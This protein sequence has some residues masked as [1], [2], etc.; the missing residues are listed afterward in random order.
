[1]ATSQTPGVDAVLFDR[2]GTLIHDVPENADPENVRPMPGAVEGVALAREFGLA[3]AVVT[4][5][6]VVGRG[7]VSREDVDRVNAR[8]DAVLGPFDVWE[9]CPHRAEDGCPCRKPRAG[10]V[11][12]A[13]RRMGVDPARIAVIGDIGSDMGAAA[14]AGAQGILV[15][16]SRTRPEEIRD[17]P[18]DASSVYDAVSMLVTGAGAP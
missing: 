13:A 2:D 3:L 16:N 10:M 9:V 14:A 11:L 18:R 15:P 1:M 7:V 12:S 6:P 8:V 17:A 4:N 5:Q